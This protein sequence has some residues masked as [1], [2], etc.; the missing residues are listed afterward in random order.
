M[1][2]SPDMGMSLRVKKARVTVYVDEKMVGKNG[3]WNPVENPQNKSTSKIQ[4]Q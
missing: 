4:R 2:K 1:E 3:T